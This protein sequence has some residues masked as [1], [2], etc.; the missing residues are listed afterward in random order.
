M[1]TK[2]SKFI[3]LILFIAVIVWLIEDPTSIKKQIIYINKALENCE[4]GCLDEQIERSV[5]KDI[6]LILET[7]DFDEPYIFNG[8]ID[9]EKLNIFTVTPE[10]FQLTKCERGNAIYNAT[11]DAVFID[12]QILNPTEL[13]ILGESSKNSMITIKDIP[14]VRGYF[15][16]ILLHEMGH[17]ILHKSSGGFF[18][19]HQNKN[20]VRY[21][22]EADSFAIH[23]FEKLFSDL[24]S[25]G[26]QYYEDLSGIVDLDFLDE[27]T[28]YEKSRVSL[29]AIFSMMNLA[30][31]FSSTNYS[32]F[33]GDESHLTFL[34][35][36][37]NIFNQIE[38]DQSLHELTRAHTSYYKNYIKRM[39]A[40][41]QNNYIEIQSPSAIQSATFT[42]DGLYFLAEGKIFELTFQRIREGLTEN[43]TSLSPKEILTLEDNDVDIWSFNDMWSSSLGTIYIECSN[44]LDSNI[45]KIDIENQ[46]LIKDQELSGTVSEK[47]PNDIFPTPQPSKFNL[48]EEIAF[49]DNPKSYSIV[50]GSQFQGKLNPQELLNSFKQKF[51]KDTAR[52]KI[53][54]NAIID[55]YAYFEITQRPYGDSNRIKG[56]ISFDLQNRTISK[57]IRF[58]NIELLEFSIESSFQV[59]SDEGVHRFI[60][61]DEQAKYWKAWEIFENGKAVE[62]VKH[63]YL[64]SEVTG[65]MHA[66][67]Q[68]GLDPYLEKIVRL[69]NGKMLIFFNRD[70]VYLFD[71]KKKTAS[72]L[73]HPSEMIKIVASQNDF[74]GL[75]VNNSLKLYLIQLNQ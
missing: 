50:E 70:S 42:N 41:V 2:Y 54:I 43:G 34:Q 29:V 5:K 35:R 18:D 10:A 71:Y 52:L 19:S 6:E 11:L 1:K 39:E 65:R 58:E 45:Y 73:F 44:D 47:F 28:Y 13:T 63:D 26:I 36:G 25:Q 66:A 7:L 40:L 67:M 55:D 60:N 17:K 20:G 64:I 14:F 61:I 32:S 51:P 27:E 37:I 21:E 75:F 8:K 23:N 15:H 22:N 69:E 4:I 59:I 53:N 68:K 30:N 74:M 46:K 12:E 62:L 16:F 57:I 38:K 3:P 9:P 31:T 24:D 49:F 56:V 72:V 33:Y 48:I